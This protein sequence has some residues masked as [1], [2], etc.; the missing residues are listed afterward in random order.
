M[1]NHLYYTHRDNS[2]ISFEDIN[3][4]DLRWLVRLE[5]KIDEQI[6]DIF[7]LS[8]YGDPSEILQVPGAKSLMEAAELVNAEKYDFV[9]TLGDIEVIGFMPNDQIILVF[10]PDSIICQGIYRFTSDFLEELFHINKY[11]AW[12]LNEDYRYLVLFNLL[13]LFLKLK[14]LKKQFRLVKKNDY[15]YIRGMTSEAYNN[16]DN[17][18]AL[19]ITLLSLHHY[20]KELN[21]PFHVI[22]IF[23]S[24]SS[25]R[26]YF[27]QPQSI[28]LK[29]IGKVYMG[30][31]LNNGEIR[32]SRF[33]LELRYTLQETE[34]MNRF[35]M[36][37]PLNEAIIDIIH[38]L[39]PEKAKIRFMELFKIREKQIQMLELINR[40]NEADLTD[41]NALYSFF[42]KVVM[43]ITVR[44]SRYSG[45]FCS[46]VF[47]C[48]RSDYKF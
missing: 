31:V 48:Y 38:T 19:Y 34:S 20:C 42:R 4:R 26:V 2:Q 37:P 25:M 30:L 12:C 29:G 46:G 3:L 36:V 39:R 45:S 1:Q 7:P 33:T 27:E 10:K 16:Y 22:E 23:M 15:F 14:N 11:A 18:I 17:R 41:E 8:A 35:S 21:A 28:L 24:E 6:N 43:N 32:D 13:Y 9:E 40:L 5:T 44:E 47:S